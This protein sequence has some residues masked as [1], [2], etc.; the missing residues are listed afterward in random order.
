MQ[1]KLDDEIGYGSHGD[2]KMEKVPPPFFNVLHWDV[3]VAYSA[4]S[5]LNDPGKPKGQ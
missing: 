5:S 4:F 1:V 3:V 2:T